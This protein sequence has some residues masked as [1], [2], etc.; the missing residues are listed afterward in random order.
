VVMPASPGFYSGQK[1]ISQ[2]IDFMV[3]K[4]LDQAGVKHNLYRRWKK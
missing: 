4:V 2:L 3:G 1:E